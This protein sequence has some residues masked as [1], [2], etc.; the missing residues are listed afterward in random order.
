MISNALDAARKMKN[1]VSV[2]VDVTHSIVVY[3]IEF[4]AV[5]SDLDIS[6]V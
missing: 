5:N 3:R 4:G 1:V 6:N 2:G